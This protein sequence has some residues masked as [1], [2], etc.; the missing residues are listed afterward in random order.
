MAHLFKKTQNWLCR[1]DVTLG[2]VYAKGEWHKAALC[3]M[4]EL[5]PGNEIDGLAV[6][7][8]LSTTFFVPQGKRVMV[9]EYKVLWLEDRR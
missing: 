1:L 9:D 8:A 3:D 2:E 5:R 4:D 6:I 7:E